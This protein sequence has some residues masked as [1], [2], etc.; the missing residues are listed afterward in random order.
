MRQWDNTALS[1]N[2]A[3]CWK[4]R[5]IPHYSFPQYPW[6]LIPRTPWDAMEGVGSDNVSGAV[7]QQERL[8]LSSR[9]T[10]T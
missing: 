8:D 7:N 3:I 5:S 2:L 10:A 6:L 4:H 1:I 9:S